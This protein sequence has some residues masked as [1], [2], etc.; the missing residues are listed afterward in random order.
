MTGRTGRER[1]NMKTAMHVL[2][3]TL[4]AT[5]LGGWPAARPLW[6]ADPSGVSA[7]APGGPYEVF[8]LHSDDMLVIRAAPDV[9][10]PSIGWVAFDARDVQV[11]EV[12]Q[13]GVWGRVSREGTD[14]WVAMRH[15]RAPAP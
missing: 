13:A 12:S 2:L 5:G 7:S 14:G 15:L 4:V 8:G 10:S 11:L 1:E 9:M 6:A 3:V